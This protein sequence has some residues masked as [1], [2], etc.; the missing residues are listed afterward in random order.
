MNRSML[1]SI[2]EATRILQTRGPAEATAA[3]QRAL[4]QTPSPVGEC[5]KGHASRSP[6]ANEALVLPQLPFRP[7]VS[8]DVGML[9]APVS[10]QR[11]TGR[12]RPRHGRKTEV[13]PG[14]FLTG[15][16]SNRAGAREYKLYVPSGH[17][18][19]ALPLVVMLHGCTQSPDD[20]ASGTRMNAAAELQPCFVLYPAQAQRANG[21]RCWNWFKSAHQKRDRGEPSIIGGMTREIIAR[22][23]IDPRRVYVAGLSAGG[24]MA[25]IMKLTHPDLFAA[26]GVHSGLPYGVAHDL[27]SALEAMKGRP[28]STAARP[29][30]LTPLIVFHGD[31]DKTVHPRNGEEILAQ[32]VTGSGA[33][34]IA[35]TTEVQQG[36]V[37]DGHPFTR[38]LYRD[39][40]GRIIAEHWVIHGAAHAWSGGSDE[41]SYVDP[42]GPDATREMLR[43]FSLWA[44]PES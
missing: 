27:P 6:E 17:H 42:R 5:V 40:A 44:Q 34:A 26:A 3:I 20:F 35:S 12:A 30:D 16:F 25:A 29:D 19:Q 43:F 13:P 10:P 22:Y 14:E 33:S 11:R 32:G 2:Q 23:G 18:A 24:A 37:P 4:Q 21:S 15:A 31:G 41:G 1:A 7:A 28:R 38:T 9:P 8:A 39:H 36:R